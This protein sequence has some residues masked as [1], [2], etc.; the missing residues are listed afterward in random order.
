MIDQPESAK[1]SFKK[2]LKPLAAGMVTVIPVIATGWVVVLVFRF[3]HRVGLRIIEAVLA[4]LNALRG[5]PTG[6]EA[7]WTMDFVGADILWLL[8]PLALLFITGLMVMNTPGRKAAQWIDTV[9]IKIPGIGF[10]Y[11]SVKQVV[12]AVRDFGGSRKFKG[13]AF[14]QYPSPG[15][16]L[17]GFITGNFIDPQTGK[18]TTSIFVPTA[19]NPISGFVLMVEDENVEH[20]DLSLEEATKM[21]ISAGLVVPPNYRM[22][23]TSS[24]A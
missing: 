14:V 4:L 3:L 10:I 2:A 22:P 12:D 9:I 13:V 21:V 8:I 20:C 19:P 1:S 11:S 6:T 24:E 7:A 5:T 23:E 16:R 18:A 15:C 17:L